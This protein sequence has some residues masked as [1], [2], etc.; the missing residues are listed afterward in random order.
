MARE[1]L[2]P[3]APADASAQ[4]GSARSRAVGLYLLGSGL[5]TIW[6]F[7]NTDVGFLDSMGFLFSALGNALL[8]STAAADAQISLIGTSWRQLEA[9]K[10]SELAGQLDSKIEDLQAAGLG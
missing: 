9:L 10:A 3:M 7:E 4:V 8:I 6:L 2:A 5:V 1:I